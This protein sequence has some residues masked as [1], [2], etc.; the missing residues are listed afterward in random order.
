MA[1]Y[2]AGYADA[3]K[4]SAKIATGGALPNMTYS[5]EARTALGEALDAIYAGDDI[6]SNL[7]EA[8]AVMQELLDQEAEE[9]AE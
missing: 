9:K 2:P 4:A 3:I 5:S 8:S 7:D 6:Q 1:K